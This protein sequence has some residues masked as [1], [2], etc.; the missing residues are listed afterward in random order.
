MLSCDVSVISARRVITS[1]PQAAPVGQL[2]GA[3]L[4]NA[5]LA[6]PP[7]DR[8]TWIDGLLG[9]PAFAPDRDLPRGCV[10]YLPCAVEAVVR[11][12]IE[13]PITPKDLFVD[14]GAGLGRVAMLVHLLCGARAVGIEI[15]PHLV[16]QGRAALAASRLRH[17]DVELRQGDAT[18]TVEP[19]GTVF[20][21]YA[22]FNG[23]AL[24]QVLERLREVAERR[25]I[26]LCVVDFDL[27]GQ[28]WLQRRPAHDAHLSIYDS[29][30]L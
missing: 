10:P 11:S 23:A 20:F 18:A 28:P 26:T 24:H 12:V 22:S 4:L 21:C 30:A 3:T 27:H 6:V 2:R 19:N 14:L 25:A 1:A 9:L 8:D 7:R 13:V 16:A 29:C 15:Q 17:V 5:L